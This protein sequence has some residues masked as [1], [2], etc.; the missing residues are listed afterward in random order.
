MLL[1]NETVAKEYCT[2]EIPFVYRTHEK[3][4]REK[5][6]GALE[7]IRGLGIPVSKKGHDI[8]PAEV[9]KILAGLDGTA[10]EPL[11]SRLLLRS[12]SRAVYSTECIGHF[13]LAAKYYCH[14]TSPIRRYPDLQIHRIIKD[15]LRGRLEKGADAPG[16]CQPVQLHGAEGAGSGA[17]GREA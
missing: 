13:G 12:M 6:E 4:D 5:M 14:F 10:K 16:G 8:T 15:D 9:Q 17:G 2:R 3:P 7:F 1:A 11:V